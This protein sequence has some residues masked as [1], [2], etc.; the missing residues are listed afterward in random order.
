MDDL[1]VGQG[2]ETGQ[3]DPVFKYVKL[4]HKDGVGFPQIIPATT[5]PVSSDKGS[6]VEVYREKKSHKRLSRLLKVVLFETSLV[7]TAILLL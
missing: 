7:S 3:G 4:E 5:S 6:N 1:A 2:L